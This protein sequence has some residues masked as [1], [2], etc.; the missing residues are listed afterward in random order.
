MHS[1]RR[2]TL[3]SLIAVGIAMS[4]VA[5]A[6]TTILAQD[7]STP[8]PIG[9]FYI[10]EDQPSAIGETSGA[11]LSI[12]DCDA[13]TPRD[14]ASVVETLL[15]APNSAD[16]MK[17]G[18]D[19]P[20]YR[21]GAPVADIANLP[22]ETLAEIED[23]LRTWQVCT[24]LGL[25][26]QQ[27]AV[28]TDQFIREDIYA[29]FQTM[30]PYSEATI[31]ELLDRREEIDAWTHDRATGAGIIAQSSPYA[32]DLTGVTS[33]SP[34]LDYVWVEVVA[35]SSSNGEQLLDSRGTVAFRLID[36]VWYVDRADITG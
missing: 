15:I 28:E 33:I 13:V 16:G 3:S 36:G 17:V 20:Q 8:V 24:A 12:H 21:P 32:I 6:A 14:R 19:A 10:P 2:I 4:A 18:D 1:F 11:P 5:P 30:T 7:V 26:Y 25:T 35:V 29:D 22:T 34:E 31:N 9:S 27:M 23:V